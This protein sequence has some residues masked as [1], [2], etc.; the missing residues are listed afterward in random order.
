MS[1]D[2][3]IA[4]DAELA[5]RARQGSDEAFEQLIKRYERRIY[6]FLAQKIADRSDAEDITQ[7]VFIKA[8]RNIHRFKSN[9]EFATWIFCIARRETT[10]F[11]RRKQLKTVE[12]QE[13]HRIDVRTPSGR[14]SDE[15]MFERLWSL[16][17]RELGEKQFTAMWMHYREG[18]NLRQTAYVMGK[19]TVAVKVLL[20]RARKAMLAVFE[21]KEDVIANEIL[22]WSVNNGLLRS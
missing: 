14:C 22:D 3:N 16:I 6:N 9:Y 19:S 13:N 21:S 11:Q 1:K 2:S 10:S 5:C 17:W 15:E 8:Y 20:H 18:M 7:T 12:I 4:G